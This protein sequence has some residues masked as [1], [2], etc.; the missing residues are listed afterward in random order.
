M[1]RTGTRATLGL[2]IAAS[3]GLWLLAGTSAADVLETRDGR[4]LTGSFRGGTEEVVKFETAEGLH[5]VPVSKV[6][7]L[8]FDEAPAEAAQAPAPTPAPEREPRAPQATPP[9]RV[10]PPGRT[11]QAARAPQPAAAP[12]DPGP[13]QVVVPAGTRLR[14]RIADSLDPRQSAQGDRF[15]A[16]LDAAIVAGGVTLAPE[17]STVY[18][19]VS[20]ARTTGP[21]PNRLQLELTEL[22]IRGQRVPI[23][24]GTQQPVT[25]G[26]DAPADAAP[27][28][29]ARIAGGTLLEFRLLQPLEV[30]V[31]REAR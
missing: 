25:E 3:A 28:Q 11:E 13:Q 19:V 23:V 27:P 24:T 20:E 31:V 15:A 21:V 9:A 14:V 12:V 8:R 2:A 17:R 4:S 7:T 26:S 30:R 16:R 22:Q 5:L 18:G 6:K 1:I 10:K 29:N